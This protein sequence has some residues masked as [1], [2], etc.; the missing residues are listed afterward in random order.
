MNLDLAES[1]LTIVKSIALSFFKQ[2]VRVTDFLVRIAEILIT[3]LEEKRPELEKIKILSHFP[4][5]DHC[6]SI[7]K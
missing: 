4:D 1:L 7:Q 5:P 3:K 6:W 2:A